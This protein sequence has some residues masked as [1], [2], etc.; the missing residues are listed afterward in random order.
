[1][2]CSHFL[3]CIQEPTTTA[4]PVWS[5]WTDKWGIEGVMTSASFPTMKVQ[6]K[7]IF[8]AYQSSDQSLLAAATQG[9]ANNDSIL[10]AGT[11][12]RAPT[13][14]N[15]LSGGTIAGIVVGSAAGGIVLATILTF[16]FLRFC[17]GYRK[18]QGRGGQGGVG[19]DSKQH[20]LDSS[21]RNLSPHHTGTPDY[22]QWSATE[23]D[24]VGQT[25][26][27]LFSPGHKLDGRAELGDHRESKQ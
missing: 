10:P 9:A 7:P 2:H 13:A 6:A 1:M 26:N 24:S 8:V 14:Q 3:W 11:G 16:I 17:F 25:R 18:M 12:H 5:L 23:L 22:A 20:E 15:S 4:R 19:G 21:L 27:E